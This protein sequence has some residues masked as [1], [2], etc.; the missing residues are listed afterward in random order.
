MP[1]IRYRA[2]FLILRR[3]R[4]PLLVLI[5]AYAISVLGL[6]LVPGVGPDG[7]PRRMDFFHAFYV[8]SYTVTTI[9]FGE[10]P[11]AFSGAQ[12]LWMTAS[13]YLGVVAWVYAIGAVIALLQDPALRQV[14]DEARFAAAVRRIRDPF[15]IVCGYGDTG[16]LLVRA[17][18]GRGMAAVV[19]DSS[20]D[21]INELRVEDLDLFVPGLCADG[22]L[23][24]KLALAGLGSGHCRGVV[25]LT[26]SDHAN[27]EV[28]IVCR[29][30]NPRVRAICRA[31][32]HDTRA[33][34]ESFGTDIVINSFDSFADSLAMALHSPDMHLLHEWLTD[35]PGSRLAER[36]DP[37]RGTWLLCGYGRFGKA[38]YRYLEY[39]GLPL[40]VV[41]KMP[42]ETGA[43]PGTIRGRGTE[44]VTL[45]EAHVEQAV[46]IVAGTDD[47]AN[48]LSIAVTAR[49][50]NPKLYVVARQNALEHDP[51]FRAADIN[52]VVQ[53]S[54]V[55]AKRILASITA[56]ALIDFL[57]LA[58]HQ[59]N[60][61]AADLIGRLRPLIGYF[62]PEIW[63]FRLD[64]EQ[65]PAVHAALAEDRAVQLCDLMR[66]PRER[67]ATLG[68]VSLFLKRG[69]QEIL[70]PDQSIKLQAGDELLFCG[71]RAA[72]RDMVWARESRAVL[73]Y[74]QTGETRPGGLVWRWW[75][76]GRR[77]SA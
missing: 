23:P 73:D 38:V 36:V 56:P 22:T 48:N 28:A 44:A 33:N 2:V 12:R 16:S 8:I 19:L 74:V 52:L 46:G 24:G 17:M 6:T 49:D 51:V 4:V 20:P 70:L 15:Y 18:T 77:P 58:R 47:D 50:L 41:E 68:C 7:L 67:S 64:A 55:I 40:V 42:E 26:G 54:H 60:Q 25:A 63:A 75:Q 21:R 13:I 65:A 76:S 34:M 10:L 45:R 31:Q 62:V 5:G 39:E 30:L 32:S 57:R 3:M 66:D 69:D 71:Q 35:V 27:L 29:L 72:A 14:L 43:P 1:A 37:P 61:W 53:R 59:D 9:G 11:Y